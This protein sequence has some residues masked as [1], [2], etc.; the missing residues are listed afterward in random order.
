MRDGEDLAEYLAYISLEQAKTGDFSQMA[1]RL[2]LD[3]L[4]DAERQYLADYLA[5]K[6]R[7][8]KLKGGRS[9]YS[10]FRKGSSITALD[11]DLIVE[12]VVALTAGGT[13]REAAVSDV[14]RVFHVKR[15]FVFELL[16][17]IDPKRLAAMKAGVHED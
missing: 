17:N 6:V 13:K 14:C 11:K 1:Q 9:L 3:M 2:R 12:T 15:S 16:R 8:R 4:S 10:F 5:G 7:P